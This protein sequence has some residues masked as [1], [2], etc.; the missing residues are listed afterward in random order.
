MTEMKIDNATINEKT[1][2]RLR[3]RSILKAGAVIAPLAITLH[4]GI[5]LAHAN[6]AT[7][8]D[9]MVANQVQVP[10]LNPDGSM[11]GVTEIFNPESGLTGQMINGHAQTHWEYIE[12]GVM[13][14]TSCLTSIIP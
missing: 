7:C 11:T 4:G 10:K 12:T 14:Y 2:T 13:G 3:R 6:S 1:E 9:K 8:V 5:S